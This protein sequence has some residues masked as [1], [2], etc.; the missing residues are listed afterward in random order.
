MT[1][2]RHAGPRAR[3]D[4]RA[5]DLGALFRRSAA[6]DT[7]ARNAIILRFL[8]L[9]RRVAREYEGRGEPA[10]DLVQVASLGLIKAVDGYSPARGDAFAAYARSLVVGE[11]RRYFRDMTWRVHVPRGLRDRANRVARAERAVRGPGGAAG[12]AAAIARYLDLQPAEVTEAQAAWAAY[13]PASLEAP[14]AI[15]THT[16]G[17]RREDILGGPDP[18]Y[19]RAEV[20]V[21]VGRALRPL[22]PRD[23][24]ALLLRV[25]CELS[26]HEIAA[27]IG[28]SQ[29]QVSRILRRGNLAMAE[30]C[31]FI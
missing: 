31:G 15:G 29:M 10:E 9:A 2:H 26:Q 28:V 21:E 4:W 19:E 27:R 5:E 6:G 20:F 22:R 24:I 18:G 12:S 8:P 3:G 30:A 25:Y 11:I 1:P 23:Q 13:W 14:R 7:D 17:A 16:G